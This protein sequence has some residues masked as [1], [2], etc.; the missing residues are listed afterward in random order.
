MGEGIQR[1]LN[2]GFKNIISVELGIKYYQ[3]CYKK[4]VNNPY[5]HLYLGDTE[6]LLEGL[7]SPINESITFWLDGHNSGHD[8]AWGKHESPLIQELEIIKRHPIKN[9]TILIDDMR[10]WKKPH[11]EFDEND[12]LAL[13]KSINPNYEITFEDGHIKDDIMVAYMN[14]Y[15]TKDVVVSGTLSFRSISLSVS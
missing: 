14:Y 4:Y 6:D 9:H 11:Y 12:I 1:A 7:I 8:T 3:K 5:V 10:C 13:L 15:Y 2:A